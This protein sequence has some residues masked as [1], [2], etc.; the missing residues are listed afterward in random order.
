V[1]AVL[2]AFDTQ[3]LKTEYQY[4]RGTEFSGKAII[5]GALNLYMD[6]INL[7]MFLLQFFG[8]RE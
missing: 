8:N 2:T 4:L 6:F 5:M 3:R 1:F 7:F